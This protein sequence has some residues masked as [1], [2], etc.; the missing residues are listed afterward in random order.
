MSEW[1]NAMRIRRVRVHREVFEAYAE[2]YR[3]ALIMTRKMDDV[4]DHHQHR[5]LID[6]GVS[7][8]Y[9]VPDV[10]AVR[11]RNEMIKIYLDGIDPYDDA[12]EQGGMIE[13]PAR[14]ARQLHLVA[15]HSTH[16]ISDV[17]NNI[18]QSDYMLLFR[19]LKK[20]GNEYTGPTSLQEVFNVW[21]TLINSHSRESRHVA[22]NRRLPANWI[23]L[24]V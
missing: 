21:G 16:M 19:N 23:R 15:R 7:S 24:V 9:K 11:A 14:T 20:I 4:L 13:F 1:N 10:E 6:N 12:V 17:I 3:A 5:A 2:V 22:Q 8:G 18:N